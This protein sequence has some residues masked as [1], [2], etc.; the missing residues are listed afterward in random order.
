MTCTASYQAKNIP[1]T[2]LRWQTSR[3][4]LST[5]NGCKQRC[6][7]ACLPTQWLQRVM[8]TTVQLSP[9]ENALSYLGAFVLIVLMVGAAAFWS[10]PEVVLPEIAA[11]E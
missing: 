6:T 1:L 10:D 4:A 5:C 11:M 7:S 2:F 8:Q 3:C 9:R